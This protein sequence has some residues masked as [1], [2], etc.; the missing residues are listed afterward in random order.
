[1]IIGVNT[2]LIQKYSLSPEETLIYSTVET[3]TQANKDN[4]CSIFLISEKLSMSPNKIIDALNNI[5]QKVF[6]VNFSI[7]ANIISLNKSMSLD[8]ML[9]SEV[10]QVDEVQNSEVVNEKVNDKQQNN[11]DVKAITE[12]VIGLINDL[13]HKK[14][15]K[16]R[17]TY[18]ALVQNILDDGKT[19]EDLLNIVVNMY[20][21]WKNTKYEKYIRPQTLFKNQEKAEEYLN[22]GV[23]AKYLDSN[24]KLLAHEHNL[25][26]ED[27]NK[28]LDATTILSKKN[29]ENG[30]D[31]LLTEEQL[32]KLISQ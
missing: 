19:E 17:K 27:T 16:N 20:T 5:R 30:V 4:S 9:N 12:N 23:N 29:K 7:N 8:D 14:Y 11:L 18:A 1:M 15:Q 21:N 26:I 22:I 28:D 6:D 10:V 3:L 25:E 13:T 32:E 31:K 24:V 2:E